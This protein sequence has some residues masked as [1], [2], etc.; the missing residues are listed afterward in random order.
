M[1]PQAED[2]P[3]VFD[4]TRETWVLRAVGDTG[5]V[6][7]HLQDALAAGVPAALPGCVHADLLR[8]GLIADPRDGFNE[9]LS[10]WIGLTQWEYSTECAPAGVL[11][12]HAGR[13]DLVF[14]TIETVGDVW[15]NHERLAQARCAF[16]PVRLDARHAFADGTGRIAVRFEAPLT[17]IRDMAARLGERPVN[18]DWDPFVFA[19]GPAMNYGW[20]FS[21]QSPTCGITGVVRLEAWRGVRIAHLRPLVERLTD[22]TWRVRVCVDIE[23]NDENPLASF[24]LRAR[25]D[26]PDGG[27]AGETQWRGVPSPSPAYDGG[28]P[29]RTLSAEILLRSPQLWWPAG[30][31]RQPLYTL[32][33]EV[34]CSDAAT[35][36]RTLVRRG[37]RL[38]VR[39]VK[40]STAPDRHGSGFTVVVNGRPIFCKGFNTTPRELF[41]GS[42]LRHG[43]DPASLLALHAEAGVNMLRIWGGGEYERDEFYDAFDRLGIMVWQDFMFS[44]GMYPQEPPFPALVEAEARHQVSRLAAH[45]CVVLWCGGNECVWG[46]RAWGW[47]ERLKPG[48]SWGEAYY[49]DLLPRVLA[50]ADGTRAYWPNSPWSGD[51]ASHPNDAARGDRHTWD[52]R[53]G[54]AVKLVPRFCSEFG[55]QS[56]PSIE[57]LTASFGA[58]GLS[59]ATRCGAPQL[60]AHLQRGPGGNAQQYAELPEVFGPRADIDDFESWHFAASLLQARA[61]R[62]MFAWCRANAPTCMGVLLW[63]HHD[64]WPGL[65]W[66]LVDDLGVPKP[67]MSAFHQAMG[68]RLLDLFA[69]QDGLVVGASN[70]PRRDPG[71]EGSWAPRLTAQRLDFHGRVIASEPLAPPAIVPGVGWLSPPLSD[72]IAHAQ[73][74]AAECVCVVSEDGLRSPP[75]FFVHDRALHLPEPRGAYTLSREGD[76]LRV[77]L[78]AET[79]VREAMP[80]MPR[81]GVRPACL[82]RQPR[83]CALVTLLP[84]ESW[85]VLVEGRDAAEWIENAAAA[86]ELLRD[87]VLVCANRF[88]PMA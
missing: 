54:D 32:V 49:F 22:D 33:A 48:Q 41:K 25:L 86:G 62:T 57:S 13:L 20:D 44:C 77:S 29:L 83:A 4:L 8:R 63:Q 81:R 35:G 80:L 1:P 75:W 18:G 10:R 5:A 64:V 40:L 16:H 47:K 70:M 45:P 3:V 55:H 84:G 42:P 6:P 68:P 50:S 71:H 76:G 36:E 43:F 31:G 78:R 24:T 11:K 56:P 46:H 37:A 67:A 88:G 28:P 2:Q 51:D 66:A 17:H 19:R 61:V 21:P 72:R 87:D 53:L 23:T 15:L 79:L 60:L 74:P 65:T 52:L 38:G 39:E 34:E 14:D 73:D 59:E 85:S 12:T 7:G 27:S 58:Q 9:S 69:T 30:E 82:A 26:A